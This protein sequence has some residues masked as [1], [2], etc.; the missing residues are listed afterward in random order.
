M[1]IKSLLFFLFPFLLFSN[2]YFKPDTLPEYTHESDSNYFSF[3]STLR[4]PSKLSYKVAILL[5]FCNQLNDSIYELN[6]DSLI[7]LNQEKKHYDFYKK[8]KI[9]SYLW[10]NDA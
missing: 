1:G 4:P 9:S 5:P 8:S 10:F 3:F 7:S 6:I 2:T